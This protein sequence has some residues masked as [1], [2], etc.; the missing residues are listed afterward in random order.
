MNSWQVH[1]YQ[2]KVGTIKIVCAIN[3]IARVPKLDIGHDVLLS[4]MY[5]ANEHFH[6]A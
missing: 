4:G 2:C 6:L 3:G 5:V 1:V